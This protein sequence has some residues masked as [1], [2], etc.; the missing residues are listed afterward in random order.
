MPSPSS[1]TSAR[2]SP[3]TRRRAPCRTIN[4]R[5]SKANTKIRGASRPTRIDFRRY[6]LRVVLAAASAVV[7][8]KE[9]QHRAEAEPVVAGQPREE[10]SLPTVRL[11][12]EPDRTVADLPTQEAAAAGMP[13][14]GNQIRPSS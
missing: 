6:I 9:K 14:R 11:H 3:D 7:A 5:D 4:P 1:K 8:P 10:F 13:L 2:L 12:V